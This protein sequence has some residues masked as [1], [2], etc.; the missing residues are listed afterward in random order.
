MTSSHEKSPVSLF[1]E[2]CAKKSIIP[3]YEV[4]ESG[5]CHP[6][7]FVCKLLFNEEVFCANASSKKKAKQESALMALKKVSDKTERINLKLKNQKENAGSYKFE[8]NYVGE[9]H[10][11][12]QK[13]LLPP[14]TFQYQQDQKSKQYLCTVNL[15]QLSMCV[16]GPSKKLSKRNACKRLLE[17]LKIEDLNTTLNQT[18]LSLDVC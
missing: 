6:K 18:A 3:T 2:W 9:L 4:K 16:S 15:M 12:T 7:V 8:K 1:Q 14:P 5:S 10:E 13:R 17:E 11:I